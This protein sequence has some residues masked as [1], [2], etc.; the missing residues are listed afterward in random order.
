M[1]EAQA[2]AEAKGI[3]AKSH[4]QAI[5]DVEIGTAEANVTEAQAIADQKKGLA[6]AVVIKEK[7]SV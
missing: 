7:Y 4:A 6:E 1:I 5:A 3:E 2:L